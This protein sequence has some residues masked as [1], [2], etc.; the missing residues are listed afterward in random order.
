M[1]RKHNLLLQE[2][3]L[4]LSSEI[5]VAQHGLTHLPFRSWCRHC[6]RATGKESPHHESSPGGVSKLATDLV[7]MGKDGTPITIPAVS[8]GWRRHFPQRGTLQRHEP[9]I[10]EATE[11]VFCLRY[12]RRSDRAIGGGAL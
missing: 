10:A 12:S 5:E 9:R 2:P 3:L 7:F 6:I 11:L 8:T 4:L 1:L